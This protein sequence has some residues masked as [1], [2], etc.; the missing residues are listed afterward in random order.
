MCIRDSK[1]A[2]A[3]ASPDELPESRLYRNY[4]NRKPKDI[5]VPEAEIQNIL[6]MT[7]KYSPDDELNCGACGYQSC[8]DKAI[9]CYKGLADPV[10]CI[11]YM[12]QKA[13][14]MA[15]LIVSAIPSAIFV[16]SAE[17]R[18]LDVNRLAQLLI[19]EP[20]HELLGE[21]I[22]MIMPAEVCSRMRQLEDDQDV[23]RGLVEVEGKWFDIT[24]FSEPTERAKVI[25]LTDKTQEKRDREQLSQ[26]RNETPVSYTHLDVYKRQL[27]ERQDIKV[28]LL[29]D[30]YPPDTKR[31]VSTHLGGALFDSTT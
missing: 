29:L 7:G 11:P 27:Y 24:I 26:L 17:G 8:R 15:N 14:S 9:A 31:M 6:A 21:P 30:D 12:R 1:E 22:D 5:E 13:E 10:M 28:N 16:V 25:I 4:R 20:L 19:K 3:E 18:I 23:Y 2:T